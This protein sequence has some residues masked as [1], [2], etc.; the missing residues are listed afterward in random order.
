MC[1]CVYVCVCVCVCVWVCVCVCARGRVHV[2]VVRVCV[3]AVCKNACVEPEHGRPDEERGTMEE[4]PTSPH[5]VESQFAA[6][7]GSNLH[8]QDFVF[9]PAPIASAF[10]ISPLRQL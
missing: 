3:A 8:V 6:M 9:L 7:A 1:V 10:A 4:I 5:P 2:C